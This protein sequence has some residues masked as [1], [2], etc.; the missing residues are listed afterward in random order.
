MVSRFSVMGS[1]FI[2]VRSAEKLNDYG[3]ENWERFASQNYFDGRGVFVSLMVSAPLLFI[4]AAMLIA[5]LREATTLLID[6]KTHELKAKAKAQQ[7][8]KRGKKTKK[9]D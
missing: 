3:S 1:I 6:V 8:G 7:G 4:S 9:Q 2:V 5:I